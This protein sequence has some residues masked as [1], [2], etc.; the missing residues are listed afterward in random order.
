MW[1]LYLHCTVYACF[2]SHIQNFFRCS[3][4][5]FI[6]DSIFFSNR[7]LSQ[8]TKKKLNYMYNLPFRQ[9]ALKFCL[10]YCSVSLIL[11]FLLSCQMALQS[12][13][14]KNDHCSSKFSNSSNWKEKAWKNQGFNGIRTRDLHEYQCDA[15]PTELRSHTLGARSIYWVHISVREEWNDGERKR[16]ATKDLQV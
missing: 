5:N 4:I 9:E 6:H 16:A 14:V 11:L 8:G 13:K 7:W 3:I 15:L 2:S 12:L 1:C 10:S